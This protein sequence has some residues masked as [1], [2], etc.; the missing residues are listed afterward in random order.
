MLSGG[1]NIAPLTASTELRYHQQTDK[2][3]NG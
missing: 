1:Q 3:L 2:I